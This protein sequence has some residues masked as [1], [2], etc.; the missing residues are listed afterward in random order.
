MNRVHAILCYL[1]L[2][3]ACVL[4]AKAQG[5]YIPTLYNTSNGL[6]QQTVNATIQD[7]QG[8][9]WFA[10]SNGFSRFDG[11]HFTN[12]RLEDSDSIGLG[13]N[14]I[15]SLREDSRR[16]IWL[17]NDDRK[18]FR[19]NP[20]TRQY[21][22][23]P[24]SLERVKSLQ[25]IPNGDIWLYL[26]DRQLVR[27][28][29]DDN[30]TLHYE[31]ILAYP[32]DDDT[33]LV[34]VSNDREGRVWILTSKEFLDYHDAQKK[35]TRHPIDDKA[36]FFSMRKR[37]NLFQ[38]G[39]NHGKVYIYHNKE[40]YH[41]L[42]QLPTEDNIVR[43]KA[44]TNV[45]SIYMTGSDGFFLHDI[46]TGEAR[47][48]SATQP[49]P[50]RLESNRIGDCYVD[51]DKNIWVT[52]L[53]NS[54]IT[55]LEINRN[56]L[57]K[58][59]LLDR[60]HRNI[61]TRN[62]IS[63][64]E[65]RNERIWF[66]APNKA[67]NYYDM[68]N[69]KLFPLVLPATQNMPDFTEPSNLYVD[70]QRNLWLGKENK[71]VLKLTFKSN[72]FSLTSPDPADLYSNANRAQGL[73]TDRQG[74]LW[75]GTQDSTIHLYDTRTRRFLG[76][77]SP[78]GSITPRKTCVGRVNVIMEDHAGNVWIGTRER[79]LLKAV[80]QDARR[81][82]YSVE[83]FAHS[84]NDAASLSDNHVTALLEDDTHRIWVGTA[85]GLNMACSDSRG[86][87]VFLHRNNR[88]KRYPSTHHLI[89]SLCQDKTGHIW[90]ATAQG[91]LRFHPATNAP[92]S[93]AF[94]NLHTLATNR[95]TF[96]SNAVMAVF[97]SQRDNALYLSTFGKGLCQITDSTCVNYT[98][99]DGL[100]SD[101]TYA[102]QEDSVGH[103]WIAT[104]SGLCR[105]DPTEKTFDTFD[106][107]FFPSDLTFSEDNAAADYAGELFFATD[108]GLLAFRPAEIEK[109]TYKPNIVLTSVQANDAPVYDGDGQPYYFGHPGKLMLEHNQ[110]SFT[111]NFRALDM[112]FPDR[113]QY[114]F[115]L[116]GF[117]DW[118]YVNNDTKA[119][120][121]N[122]PPGEYTFRVRSTNSDGRWVDNERTLHI[123]VQPS[124]WGS[125]AGIALA[126]ILFLTAFAVAAVIVL[127]HYKLK[128]R[129][130]LEQKLAEVK[131]SFFTNIVH[132][133][134]TPF[135]LIVSPLEEALAQPD[136][137]PRV[138]QNLEIMQANTRRS[139]RLIN[140]ILD[141]QK[142]TAGKMRLS[143]R[144]VE[145]RSF[146]E[147]L[148]HS[149][150]GLA[151][152]ENTR[153]SLQMETPTLTIW[154]DTDKLE[155]IFF[156]LLSN[157][158][159][160]SPRGRQITVNI[161]E[162]EGKAV[163]S[164][165]DQGYGIPEERQTRLFD[166]FES[167]VQRH[168]PRVPGTG[169]GLSLIKQ[170]VELH[171]GTIGVNSVVGS[172]STFTVELPEGKSHFPPDTEFIVEDDEELPATLV[173]GTEHDA[174][175]DERPLIL[176]VEDNAGLRS[177]LESAFAASYRVATAA[178][179]E[180]GFLQAVS[181]NPDLVV[182]D[183]RMPVVDGA[184]MI[185][186]MRATAA[187]S[188]IP[189]VLLTGESTT[190]GE[191]EGL[192][193]GIEDYIAKPFSSKVLLARVDNI[194]TRRAVLR[195]L[196]QEQIIKP[197]PDAQPA[198]GA[199]PEQSALPPAEQ[200]F[201]DKLTA[202][203]NEHL[204]SPDLGVESLSRRMGMSRS[205][206][207]KKTKSLIGLAPGELIRDLRLRRA[208]A[209]LEEGGRTISEI[210]FLTGFYDSH[211]FSNCFK[212]IY[213][214]SP[215]DYRK[216]N[217]SG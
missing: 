34:M 121:T 122:I 104:E 170:L 110:N 29:Y 181:R 53:D 207:T 182:S 137:S 20:Y 89:R 168:T 129:V 124:F 35:L 195:R 3:S 167:F 152:S 50:C 151:E 11:E 192:R 31:R 185:K 132:E 49:S 183:L 62:K 186:M 161:G 86:N 127:T 14:L 205:V 94:D 60:H 91:I 102:M 41:T 175:G 57:R 64:F 17:T 184:A 133:M 134:R 191:I 116:E 173:A 148:L 90:V 24:E 82:R 159:K 120:Y 81:Q 149:F 99:H 97:R 93:I 84:G 92:E 77:F 112:N 13:N 215:T 80:P 105:F 22:K 196:Y 8:Y 58:F 212:Q 155:T 69:H 39:S 164:V 76:Y 189:V 16:Y 68:E 145:L 115:R 67:L 1:L 214:V 174:E 108:R 140:Q 66:Y 36:R 166:R 38:L 142:L 18:I 144:R 111:I 75:M 19:F 139:I 163:I 206:L 209:L 172:G 40:D 70:K 213:G 187:T 208:A 114:A 28:F 201:V 103:I 37:L 43:I 96:H 117:D 4:S 188:H 44:Y 147:Q 119:V 160:Y 12:Y 217:R 72:H 123:R 61:E 197:E 88:L 180:E 6:P 51:Q 85:D 138:R 216:S 203:I 98:R 157:A 30:E 190:E 83:C 71:G 25:L 59:H 79:G 158:F 45:K 204:G 198:S 73:C 101:V 54:V 202:D 15:T 27:A 193:L 131:T 106:N 156:N 46:E 165:T 2:A 150:A 143:V 113:V 47:H 100:P 109:E 125:P 26:E 65:D 33:D 55:C 153:L 107:R 136:L 176:I 178:N 141:F 95:R 135:T 52:Y 171:H 23:L 56:T 194:L 10:T 5:T 21:F 63:I 42:I 48:Y 32:S 177:F 162:S 128:Q 146:F 9:M 87:T 210:A 179:G 200:A 78:D 211:Y 130:A 118:H 126:I 7:K 154:A 74:R 199:A 169:I